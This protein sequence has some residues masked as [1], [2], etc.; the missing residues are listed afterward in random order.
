MLAVASLDPRSVE[1][2]ARQLQ[3]ELWD[4]QCSLWPGEKVT[5]IDVCDPWVAA[6]Y[7]GFEVQEGCVDSP[8]TRSGFQLGGFLNRPAKLIGLS[9]QQKPQ[10]MRFTLAHEVGHVLLH[11]GLHHHREL[12]LHGITEPR[13]A[14]EP[15][16]RQ[17]NHFA[18]CF[19]VPQKQLKLAFAQSFGVER[20][21]LTD[22]VAYELLGSNFMALMNSPYD[23]LHFERVVAQAQRFRG[24]HFGA[25]HELFK[26]SPTTLAVRLRQCNLTRR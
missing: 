3:I 6:Q 15:K 14:V 18:G 22:D 13:E 10:T 19:L 20:L 16:E 23:S 21:T 8:G 11:P 2:R 12:P 4:R 24:R 17:A 25:L 1:E 26:V 7:L 9:D 5:P